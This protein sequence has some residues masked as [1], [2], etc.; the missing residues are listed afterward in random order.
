MKSLYMCAFASIASQAILRSLAQLR[1][2]G[3]D[4]VPKSW[5]AT[6]A[7]MQDPVGD[8]SFKV[9]ISSIPHR[10]RNISNVKNVLAFDAEG[11]RIVDI[12]FSLNASSSSA[13][14]ITAGRLQPASPAISAI[15]PSRGGNQRLRKIQDTARAPSIEGA[16]YLQQSMFI[17]TR[18]ASRRTRFATPF[19]L[20]RPFVLPTFFRGFFGVSRDSVLR[21]VFFL[22]AR[23]TILEK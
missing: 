16:P 23:Q 3:V 11:A 8:S 22:C 18:F 15:S 21:S 9:S 17:S 1:L 4:R 13:P 12:I 19:P 7:N 10:V 5:C 20:F 14:F 2:L 6:E